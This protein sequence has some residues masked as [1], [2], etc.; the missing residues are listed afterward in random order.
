MDQ[1]LADKIRNENVRVHQKE[2]AFYDRLHLEINNLYARRF[3]DKDVNYIFRNISTEIPTVLDVGCGT[4]Y[5]TLR[6]LNHG[7][8]V[9][10]LD[11]SQE[12]LNVLEKKLDKPGAALILAD[13]DTY[14]KNTNEVFD[15]I[16]FSSVLHHLPDYLDTIRNAMHLLRNGGIVY[17]TH[18]P[19]GKTKT[20]REAKESL[21]W[22]IVAKVDAEL[23]HARCNK[24]L[25]AC[26]NIDYSCSDYH[27][28]K[29][30]DINGLLELFS[31]HNIKVLTYTEY[32]V[33][34]YAFIDFIE[35]TCKPSKSHFRLIAKKN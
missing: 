25:S 15:V 17:I 34:K 14:I 18:E 12:M 9:F 21:L 8:K 28:E 20:N 35:N 22:K 7:S 33:R 31:K 1:E 10:A 24:V 3:T 19:L 5:L 11:I 27:C 23:F 30:I 32:N 13:V 2:A 4:G 29:G 26:G 16:T 6:F